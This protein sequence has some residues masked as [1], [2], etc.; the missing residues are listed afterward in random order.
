MHKKNGTRKGT[1]QGA[2]EVRKGTRK[3]TCQSTRNGTL[4]KSE[5]N[6]KEIRQQGH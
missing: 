1:R 6:I 3:D 5:R 2:N 4:L